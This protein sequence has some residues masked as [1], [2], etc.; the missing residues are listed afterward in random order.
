[1]FVKNAWYNAGWDYMFTQSQKNALTQSKG[2]LVARKIAGERVVLYRKPSGQ[3]VALEDRCVHRQA[4]LSLGQKEGD[5]LRC[6]Y[7]GLRF[8][9]DGKCNEIPG[10]DHIPPRACVRAFPVVEKDNWVWVWMGDPA[11]ADEKLIP[12][13]VGPGDPNWNVKTSQ[14]HVQ[15]NYRLEIANLADLTHLAWVHQGTLGAPDLDTRQRYTHIK[16]QFTAFPNALRTQY[17]VRKVPINS[18]L[19]HLFPADTQF[20][21]DF[22]ITHTIPCTWVLH[23]R[24]HIADQN[25]DGPPTGPLVA[26]TWT[27][28]A[29]TP[30]DAE[31]VDYYYSWGAARHCEFSGLSELLRD[32]L[33]DAFA[34]DRHVLEAQHVRMR[35]KPDHPMI[36]II[37]DNGPSRMLRILDSML[38]AEAAESTPVVQ[39]DKSEAALV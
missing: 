9:P 27:S 4:A 30:N 28:Q 39:P 32:N 19:S 16:P 34:E 26:D 10:Q 14:M 33:D 21:L 13:A 11:R 22:D 31:S 37:H 25:E 18:F 35:E 12:H 38:R 5:N 29:V 7:H 8:G 3:M 23:F 6:M 1:M 2:S 17:V 15:A 36:S 24:V 20:D